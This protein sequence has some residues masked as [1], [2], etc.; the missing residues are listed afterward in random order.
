MSPAEHRAHLPLHGSPD[1]LETGAHPGLPI[2][3]DP[4][5]PH[6]PWVRLEVQGPGSAPTGE[7]PVERLPSI[8]VRIQRRPRPGLLGTARS[9]LGASI[10]LGRGCR[11]VRSHAQILSKNR[12]RSTYN[13][14]VGSAA[15]FISGGV[16]RNMEQVART[17]VKATSASVG[18]AFAR[19]ACVSVNA[20]VL[21]H[22]HAR[23]GVSR[24][25]WPTAGRLG[26]GCHRVILRAPPSNTAVKRTAYRRRLPLR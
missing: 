26:F 22:V 20:T 24:S 13:T 8:L 19:S 5:L 7:A 6:V 3:E 1:P 16:R 17:S 9:P 10:A 14:L 23:L 21:L 25:A 4:P 15:V 12:Q 2:P 18:A 11:A